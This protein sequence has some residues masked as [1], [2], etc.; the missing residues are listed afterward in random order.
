MATNEP[1]AEVREELRQVEEELAEL[2]RQVARL[3]EQIGERWDAPADSAD[4]ATE[5]T[6]AEEQEAIIASLEA[7]R[8]EL[9][10]QLGQ[11]G[12][13]GEPAGS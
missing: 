7:R 4:V 6:V 13:G 12:Q 9:L 2:R 3:R 11:R 1:E 5:L 8:E 10:E